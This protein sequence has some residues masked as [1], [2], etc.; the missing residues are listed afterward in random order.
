MNYNSFINTFA[1]FILYFVLRLGSCGACYAFS[2]NVNIEGLNKIKYGTLTPL[3][4]QMLVDC[5]TESIGCGG[6]YM[7][8]SYATGVNYGVPAE[9]NYRAYSQTQGTC[10]AN[11]LNPHSVRLAPPYGA[12]KLP[13]YDEI[14]LAKCIQEYGPMTVAIY[15]EP[16]QVY[17]GG[18]IAFPLLEGDGTQLVLDHAVGAVGFHDISLL[19]LVKIPVFKCK[20]SWGTTWGEAGYFTVVRNLNSIGIGSMPISAVLADDH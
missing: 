10:E 17:L 6:G 7:D 4:E 5:D 13:E 2:A 1:Y 18:A 20:N 16:L 14:A 12:V 3:S 9:N 8:Y 15:G 11:P 19:G